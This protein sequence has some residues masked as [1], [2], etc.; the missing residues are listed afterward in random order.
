[1]SAEVRELYGVKAGD[2]TYQQGARGK[3]LRILSN[4]RNALAF[5]LTLPWTIALWSRRGF[6]CY[7]NR[8]EPYPTADDLAA[9]LVQAQA[10]IPTL[11]AS[12]LGRA[13]RTMA[14]AN[15]RDTAP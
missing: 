6:T 2:Y 13:I 10:V 7:G 14:L 4:D 1:M 5:L 3:T 9:L 11:T 8:S 12:K 15:P